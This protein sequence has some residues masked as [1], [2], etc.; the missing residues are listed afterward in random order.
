MS[1]DYDAFIDDV[2]SAV[3]QHDPTPDQLEGAATHLEKAAQ[4]W[5]ALTLG[6]PEQ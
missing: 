4:K 6:D 5:R 2:N 3:R 1:A